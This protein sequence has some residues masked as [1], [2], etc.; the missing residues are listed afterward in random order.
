ML[1]IL[2]R[3]IIVFNLMGF[4]L[5]SLFLFH[6]CLSL[7]H[8]HSSFS[9]LKLFEFSRE[10]VHLLLLAALTV[11]SIYTGRK[12]SIGLLILFAIVIFVKFAIL[13]IQSSDKFLL[14]ISLFYIFFAYFFCQL[15]LIELKDPI[16]SPGIARGQIAN[17]NVYN[18]AVT[19]RDS[20]GVMAQGWISN[21]GARSCF[22]VVSQPA[23]LKGMVSL[24]VDW[25][26]KKFRCVGKV[27]SICKNGY[28]IRTHE[29]MMPQAYHYWSDLFYIAGQR[30]L[31][32][33]S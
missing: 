33:P 18:L 20:S 16:Y 13:Y 24:E 2:K 4:C 17:Y 32:L 5:L 1:K 21:L 10:H 25:L 27:M 19:V 14:L 8:G 11:I 22:I 23:Q 31:V 26:G 7:F 9:S 6:I 15:W 29:E 30:G 28:G 12:I 3:E